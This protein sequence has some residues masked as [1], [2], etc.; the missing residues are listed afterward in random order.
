MWLP[1]VLLCLHWSTRSSRYAS[2]E[3]Y[4]KVEIPSKAFCIAL[5]LEEMRSW[6]FRSTSLQTKTF[7]LQFIS[8]KTRS[9][10]FLRIILTSSTIFLLVISSLLHSIGDFF[11][12]LNNN[13]QG[14]ENWNKWCFTSPLVLEDTRSCS[15]L[16]PFMRRW[17]LL[18]SVQQ[19]GNLF[20]KG[21]CQIF[22]SKQ[23]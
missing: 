10:T 19:V 11:L 20:A 7:V 2:M 17:G 18:H 3:S 23:N 8:L 16:Y 13:S 21:Y 5:Y 15:S 14:P 4:I 22:Y 12:V 1:S 6:S 9:S